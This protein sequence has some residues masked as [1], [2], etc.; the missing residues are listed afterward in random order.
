MSSLEGEIS[1]N[2]IE[3]PQDFAENLKLVGRTVV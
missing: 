1:E 2:E 3:E